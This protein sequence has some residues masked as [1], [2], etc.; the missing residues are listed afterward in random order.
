M[1]T[2]A[3]SGSRQ[4]LSQ[5]NPMR[6]LVFLALL[7]SA[8]LARAA[9]D[10]QPLLD[11]IEA[12]R[13]EYHV[14]GVGIAI[15][16]RDKVLWVGG[17]GVADL[18]TRRPVTADTVFRIGSVTKMFTALGLIMLNEEGK[19]RLN[20]PV[21]EFA[22][23]APYANPWEQTNPITAA[24]LLEHTAGFQ[25]PAAELFDR[26]TAK[27]LTLRE[28]LAAQTAALK[29]QWKPGLHAVYSNSGYGLAGY[30]LQTV[31]QAPYEE[32]IGQRLFAPLG[33]TSS[34][35]FLDDQVASRLATGYDQDG[36]TPLPYWRMLLRPSSGINSTPRDMA[37]F[38]RFM[39]NEGAVGDRRLLHPESIAR[40]EVP[41]T[42]LA[43][44]SGLLYGYGLGNNQK[45]RKGV[46]FNGHGG[47]AHG[48][49]VQVG[50]NHDTEMGYF[51][52]IN[53]S[54]H[55]ALSTIR[56]EIEKWIIRDL[57]VP[58]PPAAARVPDA[59]L[60]GYVGQYDL[61]AWPFT[62]TTV[63]EINR[64]RL[65][66]VLHRGVLYTRIG[67]GSP[68]EL[69]PVTQRFFRRRGEPTATCAF[70]EDVDGTLYFQEEQ[71]WKKKK[72]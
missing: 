67:S 6:A 20:G 33:M 32:F 35:F 71:S 54:R 8:L 19:L 27:P 37:A 31:A 16:S 13:A 23:D 66:V 55:R 59:V 10:L 51:V 60:R 45:F 26:D 49:L 40:M 5:S 57:K 52:S 2:P 25:D 64:M 34:G 4:V 65:S 62:G 1:R 50:Y 9:D 70:V 17:F 7:A 47:D 39:L 3:L 21:R 36:L 38:V 29:V 11:T 56:R 48:H 43:A 15:V 68:S 69:V 63:Q 18:E 12:T 30:V 46:L 22:P 44:R 42:S 28:A 24:Q 72:E 53:V 14:P 61:A 58:A 41:L